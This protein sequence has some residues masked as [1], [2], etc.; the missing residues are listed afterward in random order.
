MKTKLTLLA[1]ALTSLSH[2]ASTIA[3]SGTTNY[4]TNFLNGTG[5]ATSK[6]IWGIIV[7]SGRN[8][9][10]DGQ[11]MPGFSLAAGSGTNAGAPVQL[12]ISSGLTDDYLIV[13]GNIM[14]LT[15]NTTDGGTVG[16]NRITGLNSFSYAPTMEGGDPFKVVWF[17][18]TALG[19][20]AAAGLKYG[21]FQTA[22]L[23]T[24]PADPTPSINYQAAFAGADAPKPMAF[25][26]VPETSAAL[27]GALGA[28]GLLRRRR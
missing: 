1:L 22:T 10:A 13:S 20:T 5:A 23:N 24:I 21:T 26:V 8:G 14:N 3:F 18:A 27:L 4:A 16:I 2:A 19:G 15:T 25:T 28:L 9:F 12:S 11:Y 17:N 6:L 7:D